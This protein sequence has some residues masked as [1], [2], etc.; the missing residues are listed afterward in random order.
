M[1]IDSITALK[2]VKARLNRLEGDTTLDEYIRARIAAAEG[3]IESRGIELADSSDDM[4]MVVDYAVYQYQNRDKTE[5]FPA[6]LEHRL[7][8]RY[9][10][11]EVAT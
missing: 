1:A 2:L 8:Q 11:Q 3:E 6:W 10:A 4:L 5:D 9:F 7:R